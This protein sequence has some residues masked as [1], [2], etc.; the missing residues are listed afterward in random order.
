MLTISGN[1]TSRVF[2]IRFGSAELSGLTITGGS[3][4]SAASGGGLYNNNGTLA[5]SN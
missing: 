2:E 4:G 1:K 5:L 3:G